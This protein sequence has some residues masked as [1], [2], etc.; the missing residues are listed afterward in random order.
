MADCLLLV[1]ATSVVRPIFEARSKR[2]RNEGGQASAEADD[3]VV[4]E[5]LNIAERAYR[6]LIADTH[7]SHVI[8]VFDHGGRTFRH[9]LFDGYKADREATPPALARH[10][11]PF[12]Q[13]LRGP[14]ALHCVSVGGVEADDTLATLALRAVDRGYVVVVASVDK[15]MWCLIAL[16]VRV[17]HPFE[18]K[19]IDQADVQSR[20][21]VRPEQ[22]SDLLALMGDRVDG[23]PGVPKVGKKTAAELLERFGC[24]EAI[25]A[26]AESI[27]GAVGAQI[28]ANAQDLRMSYQ[29]AC[30]K[31]DVEVS[32][33]PRECRVARA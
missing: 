13:Y 14:G 5:A 2:A 21:G 12:Q 26:Q 10:I 15:D 8:L 6:R 23:I 25:L 31:F 3:R 17:Y 11:V 1:D 16:G 29:L 19:W 30:L 9:D 4:V 22:M 24:V 28:R 33:S 27:E 20:F 32:V 7:A 18:R